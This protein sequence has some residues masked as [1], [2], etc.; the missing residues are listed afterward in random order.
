MTIAM[1]IEFAIIN[2]KKPT[3]V[4]SLNYIGNNLKNTYYDDV[5]I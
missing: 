5:F 1:A 4:D 3:I 2:F